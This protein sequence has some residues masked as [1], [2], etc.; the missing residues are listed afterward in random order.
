MVAT[1]DEEI[2]VGVG[3]VV[4]FPEDEKHWHGATKDSEFSHLSI[5]PLPS[6]MTQLEK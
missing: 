3:D 4:F 5:V 2:V 1:E 6:K